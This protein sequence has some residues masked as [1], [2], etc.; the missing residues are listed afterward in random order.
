M[1]ACLGG[2]WGVMEF[3]MGV[4]GKL[5]FLLSISQIRTYSNSYR[6]LRPTVW[7]V[8]AAQPSGQCAWR[9]RLCPQGSRANP[10][11]ARRR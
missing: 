9:C 7:A 5:V 2:A 4:W 3:D 11:A 10:A 1:Q 8:G 6:V